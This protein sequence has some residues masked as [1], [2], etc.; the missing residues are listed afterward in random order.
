MNG[1]NININP[2]HIARHT[3]RGAGAQ[4]RDAAIIDIAQDL[5]LRQLHENGNLENMAF[6]GGTA[7]RKLYAGAEGRFSLDLDFSIVHIGSVPDETLMNLIE[8]VD[9]ARIGPFRYSMKERRGKW[10]VA[11]EYDFSGVI[12]Q[13][14]KLD[15]SPPP[16]LSPIFREWVPMPVQKQYGAPG[17]PSI[18]TIRLEENIAEKIA[19][20]NR[21][22][23]ARDLYDLIWVVK[24]PN[25]TGKLDKALIRRLA[26][27]KIWV[28]ANGI[29]AKN[30]EWKPGHESNP[31]DPAEW[32]RDRSQGD[33]DAEDI[34]ALAV[35][36]PTAKELSD[37]IRIHYSFLADLD[38]DEHLLA[39]IREVDRP[40]ALKLL[41][42]LPDHRLSG[43]GLY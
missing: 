23:P 17:L 34:G 39:A 11:Y 8:A 7:L 13:S 15:I 12:M 31:F 2:G 18:R 40:V 37:A 41:S 25:I 35:P 19:R 21:A 1:Q 29:R 20:L 4:G 26:V 42:E 5:L 27:L 32:L 10:S 3:P 43:I 28:D 9:G 38:D 24:N 30:T 33:F 16:W 14:S 22:T 36:V 6:K